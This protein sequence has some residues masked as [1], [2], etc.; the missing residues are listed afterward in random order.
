MLLLVVFLHHRFKFFF[1]EKTEQ[2][3]KAITATRA[4]GAPSG[5]F[6]LLHLL[7]LLLLKR[8]QGGE[9]RIPKREEGGDAQQIL[10]LHRRGISY[11]GQ[12]ERAITATRAGRVPRDRS[13]IPKREEGADA[14]QILLLLRIIGR[15]ISNSRQPKRAITATRAGRV[16]RDGSQIPK[17]E[18]GADAYKIL[19]LLL[20]LRIIGRGISYSAQPKRAITATRAGRVPRDGSRFPKREEGADADKITLLLLQASRPPSS[21]SKPGASRALKLSAAVR[22]AILDGSFKYV[23]TSNA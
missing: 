14:Y 13:Q 17:R 10:L 7:P 22:Q 16:P 23:I 2:E 18:E 1:G 9:E 15:G 3:V 20:L 8:G 21:P 19:L 4:D 11:S 5:R 6:R 12:P